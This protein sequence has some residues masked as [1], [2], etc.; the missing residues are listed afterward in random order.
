ML[1][2]V[3]LIKTTLG[4]PALPENAT[5]VVTTNMS[6]ITTLESTTAPESTATPGSTTTILDT[7]C[8]SPSWGNVTE[9][10]AS[11]IG[12]ENQTLP[13]FGDKTMFESFSIGVRCF[14][15]PAL[16]K[17]ER[18]TLLVSLSSTPG[19]YCMHDGS[20]VLN[21]VLYDRHYTSGCTA[22]LFTSA[23]G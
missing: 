1:L 16:K 10:Y 3:L 2:H 18:L 14:S 6:S 23:R 21:P 8:V 12:G 11:Y 20:L 19:L 9:Y 15:L 17:L 13:D 4:V 22:I 7:L 5:V